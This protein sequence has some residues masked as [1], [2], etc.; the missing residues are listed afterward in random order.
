[1]DEEG[2]CALALDGDEARCRVIASNLAHPLWSGIIPPGRR[3]GFTDQFLTLATG[4]FD[5]AQQY[6][7]RRPCELFCGF[8]RMPGYGATPGGL[9]APG[10][11]AGV[12]SQL[13]V[14]MLGLEPEAG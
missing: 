12:A 1:M 4:L 14:E 5:A 3:Y 11:A 2:F 13:L 8:P 6:E 7:G 9:L 10:W